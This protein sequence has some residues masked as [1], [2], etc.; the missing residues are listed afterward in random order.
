MNI[1]T[2]LKVLK[3][4]NSVCPNCKGKGLVTNQGRTL[5]C[6]VCD[7]KGYHTFEELSNTIQDVDKNKTYKNKYKRKR[8]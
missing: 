8:K 6:Q 4:I 5:L 2:I 1:E 3:K 7:S